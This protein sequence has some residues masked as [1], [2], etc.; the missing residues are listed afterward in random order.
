[1][2][3]NQPCYISR[4][5]KVVWNDT[6]HFPSSEKYMTCI[7]QNQSWFTYIWNQY[8]NGNRRILFMTL[9]SECKKSVSTFRKKKP[10]FLCILFLLL[11]SQ[12]CKHMFIFFYL[13]SA[14][15]W[16]ICDSKPI[17]NSN[18]ESQ[19]H[20]KIIF[21]HSHHMFL[22]HTCINGLYSIG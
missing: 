16:I 1:M 6:R 3:T 18:I 8:R 2:H 21:L 5:L 11:L 10:N 7:F 12:K 22:L 20:P 13:G 9:S 14:H 4:Q 19:F 15:L 17:E